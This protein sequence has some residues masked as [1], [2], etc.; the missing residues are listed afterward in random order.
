MFPELLNLEKAVRASEVILDSEAIGVDQE[1]KNLANF[2][3][4]MT[5][6]RKHDIEKFA[7]STPI[8]FFVFDI[9][10]RDKINLMNTPYIV[11]K[12]ILS[13]TIID[14]PLLS[15][16]KESITKDSNEIRLEYEKYKK[17]GYEGILVKKTD[18]YYVPGRTG[19]RWVKMKEAEDKA[20]KIADTLDLVVM[21]YTRGRGK[22]AGFGVGQF[23]V[24]IVDGGK[25]KTITKVGTG[26]TDS[27]FQKLNTRLTKIAVDEM[28]Q[29]FDVQKDYVP[30]FWVKPE[31]VV[32]IA[33][34][35][36][37][38]SPKHTSGFAIR[39]PR[40]ISFRDDKDKDSAT[41]LFEINKLFKLQ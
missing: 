25:I 20:G 38:K 29:E 33:G 30:D 1:R 21:G 28:P 22:R 17:Q 12:K 16:V 13:E 6:R 27:Q 10:Y 8:K 23:L 26:L 24:G 18:G 14:G 11:R 31:V 9:L 32:E 37:T 5:R 36:I 15:F 19:W 39:F 2:Q 7:K 4:T 35:E 3:S 34:D 41:T 40:L